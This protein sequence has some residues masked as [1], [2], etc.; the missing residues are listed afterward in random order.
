MSRPG[1]ALQPPS[2]YWTPVYPARVL[3]IAP[4]LAVALLIASMR[5]PWHHVVITAHHVDV[6]YGIQS[7]SWLLV[8]AGVCALCT[9]RFWVL[10]P[11]AT[12]CWLFT[13]MTLFTLIGMFGD[14]I[15]WEGRAGEVNVQAYF[16]PGFFLALGAT[17]LVVLECA[18]AWRFRD[19]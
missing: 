9:V 19:R 4:V 7:A 3:L 18:L 2:V 17:A 1:A 16:G 13:I 6:I 15:D 10:R 14:Y 11:G 8:V 5:L 12:T